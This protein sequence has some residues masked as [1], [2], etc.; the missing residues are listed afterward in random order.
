MAQ[1]SPQRALVTVGSVA[2]LEALT[3]PG[4][5]IGGDPLFDLAQATLPRHSAMFQ[6]G[7]FEGYSAAGTLSPAQHGRLQRLRL[8]LHVDDVV[9]RGDETAHA[10]LS[11]TVAE[12]LRQLAEGAASEAGR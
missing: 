12:A 1:S 10:R 6:Q 5:L 2:Q 9:L 7:V 3:H 4:E 11:A 8:L